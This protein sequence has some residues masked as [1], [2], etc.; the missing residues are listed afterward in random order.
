MPPPEDLRRRVACSR[1]RRALRDLVGFS[2]PGRDLPIGTNAS[3]LARRRWV[4]E[5]LRARGPP[6]SSRDLLA[7]RRAQGGEFRWGDYDPVVAEATA[8]GVSLLGVLAYGNIWTSSAPGATGVP[9]PDDPRTFAL[10][11]R[12]RAEVRRP[13]P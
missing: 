5:T 9:P 7:R 3:A 1:R 11:D 4:W 6:G 8:A 2:L 10:R 13:H 12:D